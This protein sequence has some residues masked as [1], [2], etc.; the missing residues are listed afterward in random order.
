MGFCTHGIT[1][2]VYE[3][4]THGSL[5]HNLHEVKHDVS[6]VFKIHDYGIRI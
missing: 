4:I 5:Y 6:M 2:L 3:F 1:A